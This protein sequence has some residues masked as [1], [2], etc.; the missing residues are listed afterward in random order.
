MKLP[1]QCYKCGVKFDIEETR[2]FLIIRTEPDFDSCQDGD[3]I[4][5]QI[6]E[7]SKCHTLYRARWKL[8]SF[9]ML[10]EVITKGYHDVEEFYKE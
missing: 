8:E 9:R 4:E 7:C 3:R 5:D 1:E 6:F 10:E 2:A